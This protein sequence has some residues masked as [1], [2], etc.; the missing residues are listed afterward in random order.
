MLTSIDLA[1]KLTRSPV[2]YD[3]LGYDVAVCCNVAKVTDCNT[4]R[5]DMGIMIKYLEE[6]CWEKIVEAE[7]LYM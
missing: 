1:L 6:A 3:D 5:G 2:L 7:L 4:A